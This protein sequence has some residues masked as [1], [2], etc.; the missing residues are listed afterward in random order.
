MIICLTIALCLG[1]MAGTF[2]MARNMVKR[3][4]APGKAVLMQILGFALVYACTLGSSFA[5]TS[6]DEKTNENASTSTSVV[7]KTAADESSEGSSANTVAVQ[8]KA[9]K[10]WDSIA[11]A[12]SV[13]L[14]CIGCGVAIASAAPAAIGAV[15]EDPKAFGKAMI[16]VGLAESVSLFGLL[17]AI[18]IKFI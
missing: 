11:M 5:V 16:F 10:Y 3:G 8:E 18:L 6:A 9:N 2:L 14:A 17:I 12:L 15:S 13:G 4:F 1:L 7:T